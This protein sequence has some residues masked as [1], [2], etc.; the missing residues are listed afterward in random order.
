ML[1]TTIPRAF[2]ASTSTTLYPVA[3]T[4]MYRSFGN[5]SSTYPGSA[6]LFVKTISASAARASASSARV[7]SYT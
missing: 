6:V 1:A 5:F 3:S 7:R 2:A 4:P